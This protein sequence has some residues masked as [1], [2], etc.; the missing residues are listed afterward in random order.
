MRGAGLS[1]AGLVSVCVA[2]SGCVTTNVMGT[3]GQWREPSV[4]VV[5]WRVRF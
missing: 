3:D 4:K 2:L 1:L 5:I